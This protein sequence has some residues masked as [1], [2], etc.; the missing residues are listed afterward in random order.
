MNIYFCTVGRDLGRKID[1]SPNPLLSGDYDINQLKSTFAFKSIQVQHVSHAIGK[2]TSSKSFRNDNISSYFLKFAFPYIK[3]SL[4]LFF[5]TSIESSQ[6]PDKW[7]IARITPIF[8]EGDKAYKENYQPIYIL[9]VVAG[10]FEKLI[11]DQLYNYLNKNN[12]I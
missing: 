10:L 1:K 4:V 5:N 11:F 3:Y 12:L 8:K 9:P 6:L 7:K 2:N